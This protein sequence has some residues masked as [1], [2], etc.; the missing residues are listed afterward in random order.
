M[1]QT[2]HFSLKGVL[3]A[4]GPIQHHLWESKEVPLG[5]SNRSAAQAAS[6]RPLQELL[7]GVCAQSAYS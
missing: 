3:H 1:C 4:N 2:E 7:E 5:D 6:H